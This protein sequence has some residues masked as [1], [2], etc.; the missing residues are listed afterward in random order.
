MFDLESAIAD[1]RKQMLAAGIQSPTTLDEL[2]SHLR[3][4]MGRQL[5][6]GMGDMEAFMVAVQEIGPAHLVQNEFGK[7]EPG[8]RMGL[9]ILLIIGWLAA[10]FMLMCGVMRIVFGW[11]LFS[12]HPSLDLGTIFVALIVLVAEAGIWFLARAGRDRS[13][14]AASLLV[15]LFLAGWGI[16]VVYPED[17]HGLFGRREPSPLW[18]RGGLT[19]LLWVPG[20]F[21][22]WWERRHVVRERDIARE[23]LP[24]GS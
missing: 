23:N 10:G 15:C 17:V 4:E 2:E 16:L 5:R 3:E 22:I 7:V 6:L 19:L 24:A 12:F 9:L 13:I 8:R 18:F 1:W 21:W 11:D 14:R 20:I